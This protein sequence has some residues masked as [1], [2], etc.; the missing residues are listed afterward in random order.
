M[1]RV[2]VNDNGAGT[3]YFEGKLE[4]VATDVCC[5]IGWTYH[6]IKECNPEEAAEFRT[7]IQSAILDDDSPLWVLEPQTEGT[8]IVLPTEMTGGKTDDN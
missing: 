1:L 7:I 3:L 6:S 5:A 2:E 4:T 8:T